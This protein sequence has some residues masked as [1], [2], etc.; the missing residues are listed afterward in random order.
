MF[1]ARHRYF[2][3]WFRVTL[4]NGNI[5]LLVTIVSVLFKAISLSLNNHVTSDI[6]GL[7]QTVQI[8][9]TSV[10]SIIFE[11]FRCFSREIFKI[12]TTAKE[13]I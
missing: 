11:A 10:P 5:N 7:A 9:F 13:E 12:G 8:K 6:L 4:P 1:A 3:P 2:P